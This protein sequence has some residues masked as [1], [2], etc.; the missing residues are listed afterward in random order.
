MINILKKNKSIDIK[1]FDKVVINFPKNENTIYTFKNIIK[2]IND[3]V[4]GKYFIRT[5]DLGYSKMNLYSLVITPSTI[6]IKKQYILYG[7]VQNNTYKYEYTDDMISN[8]V[9]SIN[10]I[11]SEL[12]RECN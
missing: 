2:A 3:I 4:E 12:V 6:F 9:N 7:S 5:I 10:N 1:F 8:I 11:I